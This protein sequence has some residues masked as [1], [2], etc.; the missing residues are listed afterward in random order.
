MLTDCGDE[1]CQWIGCD[2]RTSR[3]DDLFG[4]K[5]LSSFRGTRSVLPQGYANLL[6]V[7]ISPSPVLLLHVK[8]RCYRVGPVAASGTRFCRV[9]LPLFVQ[10]M[11]VGPRGDRLGFVKN[12]R[13]Q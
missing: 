13:R 10:D 4:L 7:V 6:Q 2:Q 5:I 12:S 3:A 9:Q 11:I 1:A 8:P